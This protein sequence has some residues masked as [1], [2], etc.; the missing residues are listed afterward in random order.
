MKTFV[1]RGVYMAPEINYCSVMIERGFEVS[2]SF[3]QPE[4]GGEDNL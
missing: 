1:E 3:E 2:D 4:F